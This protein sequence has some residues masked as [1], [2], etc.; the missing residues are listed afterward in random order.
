MLR[1]ECKRSVTKSYK[2]L[3]HYSFL[4][5]QSSVYLFAG[6]G[7]QKNTSQLQHRTKSYRN[8]QHRKTP[9]LVGIQQR[10][11]LEQCKEYYNCLFCLLR[12]HL[13]C[14]AHNKHRWL[15]VDKAGSVWPLSACIWDSIPEQS[16]SSSL[17]KYNWC[18]WWYLKISISFL[19]SVF[20]LTI[21][22]WKKNTHTNKTALCLKTGCTQTEKIS[23]PSAVNQFHKWNKIISSVRESKSPFPTH[24]KSIRRKL[25]SKGIFPC[26]YRTQK[27][28]SFVFL[29]GFAKCQDT[30]LVKLKLT[31]L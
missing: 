27:D 8:S 4:L 21:H 22:C 17:T 10:C 14:I 3:K 24:S 1:D 19:D 7:H 31:L 2:N 20:L 9:H 23:S 5:K 18:M 28:T 26:V 11:Q 15:H 29:C 13:Q 25:V 16:A 30:V 12:A 6:R